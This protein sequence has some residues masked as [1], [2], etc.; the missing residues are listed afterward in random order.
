MARLGRELPGACV[1]VAESGIRGP[2]DVRRLL[3][4]GY[5]AF[6]VGES[7]LRSGEPARSLRRLLGQGSTEVKLCGLTREEDVRTAVALGVDWIGLNLSPLSP[8]RVSLERAGAL[9]EAA[10]GAGVV[11]VF[12]GNGPEEIAAAVERL[13]PDAVQLHEPGVPP[14]PPAWRRQAVRVGQDDLDEAPAGGRALRPRRPPPASPADR[15]GVRRS[16]RHVED[17]GT[18]GRLGD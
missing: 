9:R 4:A 15:D 5:G 11:L 10:E 2:A 13:R 7:L 17:V 12:A 6:L 3:A 18:A 1:R 16:R 14:P 8:R